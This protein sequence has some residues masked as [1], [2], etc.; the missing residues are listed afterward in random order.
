MLAEQNGTPLSGAGR[1][2]LASVIHGAYRRAARLPYGVPAME[3][4]MIG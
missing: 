3:L 4:A 2:A 1:G